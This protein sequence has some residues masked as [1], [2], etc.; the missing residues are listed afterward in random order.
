MNVYLLRHGI[1]CDR[2]AKKFPNDDQRPLTQEGIERM[3]EA[4]VGVAALID[5]P[6][7]IL[8]SPLVRTAQ[9]AD[10]VAKSLGCEDRTETSDALRPGA[11]TGIVRD[12]LAARAP[13]GVESILLVGHEPDMGEIAS[14]LIGAKGSV[15]EFKKGSLCAIYLDDEH[16][17]RPG[18]LLWHLTAK[19]LRA[20]GK[21]Q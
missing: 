12:I 17:N 21:G 10:V 15:V 3:R 16:L 8:T 19:Q 7:L 18:V 13:D 2:N 1:A 14:G 20:I 9:T 6:D 4:A 5:Q 11:T